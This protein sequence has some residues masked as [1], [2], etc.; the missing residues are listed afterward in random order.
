MFDS[1]FLTFAQAT[2]AQPTEDA[3]PVTPDAQPL[4]PANT[5]TSGP[6][7]PGTPGTT[8]QPEAAKGTGQSSGFG[9]NPMTFLLPVMAIV[10]F[11]MIF[12]NPAKRERK[13]REA[14]LATMKKGDRIQ[15]IGGLLGAVVEIRDNEVVVESAGTRLKFAKSAIQTVLEDKSAAPAKPAIEKA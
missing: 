12:S 6:G 13:K 9:S 10:L 8:A 14:L 1:T 2:S 15:T 4:G 3:R 11:F 5:G 7:T